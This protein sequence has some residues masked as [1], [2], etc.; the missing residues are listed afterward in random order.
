M[1]ELKKLS[2]YCEF[3]ANLE[4]NLRDQFVCGL[5]SDVIRQR[6]FAE[7]KLTYT[8]AIK[9]SISLEAAERDAAAVE[10]VEQRSDGGGGGRAAAGAPVL[11]LAPAGARA[12]HGRGRTAPT[13]GS[14]TGQR[15]GTQAPCT[16]CGANTHSWAR[17]RFKNF[18]CSKCKQ[19]G[20]LRRQCPNPGAGPY[21][22]DGRGIHHVD[23]RLDQAAPPRDEEAE[24]SLSELEEDLHQLSLNGYRPVSITVSVGNVDLLME[25]DTGS[26]VSCIS[27]VTYDQYFSAYEIEELE[28]VLKSYDGTKIK[29]LGIIKPIVGYGRLNR[30]LELFVIEGGTTSLLGRHWLTELG[31]QIPV[32]RNNNSLHKMQP[33]PK[34]NVNITNNKGNELTCLLDRYKGLFSGGLGRYS[35]GKARLRVREGS[36]PVFCRARP[37][38]YALR[39][40][41]EAELDGMLREGIIE[42]V[43]TADWATP[44]VPV[45]KADGGI[46]ICADY[47]V[48]L[49]PV[50][51]I[52]KYPLPKVEDLFVGLSGA[53]YFSKIDLSQ[54]YNQIELEDPENLT[55][56][57][58]HKGLFKYKRLV[59]GLSS[60]P[61][62]F[63]RIM[64]SLLK[65]IPNVQVFLDDI[66]LAS[67]DIKT[68]LL[69]IEEVF[70]KLQDAGLKLKENKCFFML[71]EVKY[72]GYIISKDG[73]KVDPEKVDA[74]V[75]IASPTNISQLR[76]FIG[77]VNFYARFVPN[78]STVLS[79]LYKLLKKGIR[80]NWNTE[81]ELSFNKIKAILCSTEVLAHYDPTKKLILTCDASPVGIGG[82][83]TQV[84]ADGCERP[85][86]YISRTLSPAEQNYSQIDREALAIVFSLQKFHQYVYGRRFV[87][88]TDHKPLVS[89]FGPKKG[90]PMMAASRLQRWS[91][92]VA[93][94]SYDI[95]YINTTNNGADSLSRLPIAAKAKDILKYPEQSYLHY[96]NNSMLLDYQEI[97]KQTSRDPLLSRILGYIRDG[98]PEH[99]EIRSLQP[100]FNRKTELYEELGC[101]MWGHRIVIPTNCTEK[102]L[103]DLHECHM[104]IVKTKAIARSYVWWA[105][106]DEAVEAMCRC[107]AVCA[108]E[109]DA[110]PRRPPAPWPYPNQPW[111]RIHADFLGPI[112]GK[113]YL[114]V[115]DARTKWLEVFNIPSTSAHHVISK[116]SELFGRWGVAK[117]LVTDNGPPFTSKEVS[118]YLNRNGVQHLF[119]APY[120]PASNGA[121]ENAVRTVKRVI[122]KARRQNHNLELAAEA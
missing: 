52:D 44:L 110:P 119:S 46:R 64:A 84:G 19:R 13:S 51:L 27:K 72:L 74:V 6:L 111:A 82:V 81:C 98:W 47:K 77:L 93:A 100:Y 4:D 87:L 61:G 102:V 55:V 24:D 96:V 85:V 69:L 23:T 37:L 88:R 117:Q 9:L 43:E 99:N 7:E 105:G 3:G 57:N 45:P 122:K 101:I 8:T 83:L 68:H 14:A 28:L 50:L 63:Q 32:L 70:K 116:F 103:N 11:S 41:V 1:T 10:H 53:N 90:I 16:A 115:V 36:V 73:I 107:C 34:N 91:V 108:A 39:E 15:P 33:L 21:R 120:H 58:T 112:D 92:I 80:W 79:P 22:R 60:S 20:H 86:S 5:R 75:K 106:I 18:I 71:N 29:P 17:C 95:E 104:G 89:I 78:I 59:Y 76:S 49:N 109:A 94:Y 65:D 54:A 67:Q 2:K 118:D 66:I 113:L 56:I 12:S 31:I 121:A 26:A 40:R 38:P 62:I 114:V 42:P 48:T 30:K 97:K 25:V 35:R